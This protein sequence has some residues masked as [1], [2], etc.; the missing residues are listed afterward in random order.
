MNY[1]FLPTR[2][3]FMLDFVVIAMFGVSALLL[4]S[5]FMVRN[6]KR[7]DFHKRLQTILGV[8]LLITVIAFEVDIQFVKPHWRDLAKESA[9]FESGWVDRS[10]IFHL[11]FAVPTPFVWGFLIFSAYRNMG[12]KYE[13]TAYRSKHRRMGWIGTVLMLMTAVTGW[14]FYYV[15]FVA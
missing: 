8:V 14:V 1:G 4:A 13:N 10:L 6:G 15:S 2:G 3:T 7:Y 9:F 12:P 11:L 5:V